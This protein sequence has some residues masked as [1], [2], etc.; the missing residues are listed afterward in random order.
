ML[1]K[2]I[3]SV[4]RSIAGAF[5]GR[6]IKV[7]VNISKEESE[8]F[9]QLYHP[10]LFELTDSEQDTLSNRVDSIINILDEN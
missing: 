1:E 8:V 3:I 5:P 4:Y 10:I 9:D 6:E 7:D 2:I